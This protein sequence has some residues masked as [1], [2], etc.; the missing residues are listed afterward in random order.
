MT[1]QVK[2]PVVNVSSGPS[3]NHTDLIQVQG[4]Q[5]VEEMTQVT[6]RWDEALPASLEVATPHLNPIIAGSSDVG[7]ADGD[8]ISSR[9]LWDMKCTI[10]LNLT[11]NHIC[12]LAGYALLEY[13]DT[14][15]RRPVLLPG[16]QG[17]S[18]R[19]ATSGDGDVAGP[20]SNC[21]AQVHCKE[22]TSPTQERR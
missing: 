21:K 13:A 2:G 10:R 18:L 8:C 22:D 17:A 3:L 20:H 19:T 5:W 14:A 4:R 11:G 6:E 7:G 12:K 15:G 1:A 16:L 9:T